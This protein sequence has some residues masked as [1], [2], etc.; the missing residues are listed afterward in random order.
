LPRARVAASSSRALPALAR[1][2]PVKER[3]WS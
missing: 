3:A 2:V 1:V